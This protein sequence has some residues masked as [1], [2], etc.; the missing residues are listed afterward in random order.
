MPEKNVGIHVN[1]LANCSQKSKTLKLF[2][3]IA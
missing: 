2:W 3:P 1:Q